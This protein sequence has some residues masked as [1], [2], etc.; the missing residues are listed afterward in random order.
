MSE[1]GVV[2]EGFRRKPMDRIQ[3]ELETAARTI[4]GSDVV[5]D[6]ESPMG[7]IV[8]L[9][10][11]LTAQLWETA[12]DAYQSYDPDQA[13]GARLDSLARIRLLLRSAEEPDAS[14]RQAITNLGQAR[15][16][17]QDIM[18]AIL[19]VP[20]VTYAQVFVNE[21]NT[22]DPDTLLQPGQ[23]A[24]AV[25]GGDDEAI[26]G[27]I[28][29]FT[30]PG[31][32]LYGNTYVTSE[33]DGYCRTVAIVRPI[34]IPVTLAINVRPRRDLRDCPPPS[35]VAIRDALVQDFAGDRLLRNGDDI[36]YFRVRS[37]IESRFPNVEVVSFIGHR[38]DITLGLNQPVGIGFIE[39]AVITTSTVTVSVV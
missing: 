25:L 37:A 26:A 11:L 6:P 23:V 17:V 19:N 30:V 20:G 28:R 22:Q 31:I 15:I 16:D 7:Q 18:R 24:L 5:L 32:S 36:T 35:P 1:Y 27:A 29:A 21:T 4:F 9:Y 8:G 14:F 12:E 34:L 13:E 3:F 38:D 33:V 10:T 2:P 39:L